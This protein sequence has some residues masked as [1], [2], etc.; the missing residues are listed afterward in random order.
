MTDEAS[1]SDAWAMTVRPYTLTGGRTSSPIMT[2]EAMVTVH[3]SKAELPE[4]LLPELYSIMKL[5]RNPLSVAEVSAYLALPLQVT[6][7]LI[8][9]LV[10]AGHLL[11]HTGGTVNADLRPDIELLDR[12]LQGL[13]EL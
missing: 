5:A 11:L 1:E 3:S 2:V 7:V 10:E 6:K 4:N 8:G 9:D 12:V 13:Q